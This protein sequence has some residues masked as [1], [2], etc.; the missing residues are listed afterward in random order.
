MLYCVIVYYYELKFKKIKIFDFNL[1]FLSFF[2]YVKMKIDINL[3]EIFSLTQLINTYIS[4]KKNLLNLNK[5]GISIKKLTQF[6]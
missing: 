4:I 5:Q 6:K 1:F 2:F 3:I